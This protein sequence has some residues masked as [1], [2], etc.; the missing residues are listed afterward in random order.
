MRV[1]VII[2]LPNIDH[3]YFGEQLLLVPTLVL[4]HP[5]D[6]ASS[7]LWQ[8][9]EG[10]FIMLFSKAKSL[11][12]SITALMAFSLFVQMAEGSTFGIVPYLNPGLTGTVAGIIGAGGNAGA[13]VF[14]IIFQQL[15]YRDAFFWMGASTSCISILSTLV[16]IKLLLKSK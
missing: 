4:T 16:W 2:L 12:G 14:S 6:V 10:A 5:T 7:V 3:P 9:T 15:P 8:R 13:V 11:A 1:S